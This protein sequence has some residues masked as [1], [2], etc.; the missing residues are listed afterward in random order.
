V[1]A[2]QSFS[3]EERD[4]PIKEIEDILIRAMRLARHDLRGTISNPIG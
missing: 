1:N 2:P 3:P 4:P